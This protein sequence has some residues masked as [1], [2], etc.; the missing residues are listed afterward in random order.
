MGQF[1]KR[2]SIGFILLIVL[3]SG[4]GWIYLNSLLPDLDETILS[5]NVKAITKITRDQWGVAHINANSKEDAN[6]AYG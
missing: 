5:Q 6:F 1:L 2:V 3:F 4:G